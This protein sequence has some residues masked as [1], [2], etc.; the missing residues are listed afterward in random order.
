MNEETC[1]LLQASQSESDGRQEAIMQTMT[2]DGISAILQSFSTVNLEITIGCVLRLRLL[3][4]NEEQEVLGRINRL[5]THRIES[6]V[7]QQIFNCCMCIYCREMVFK[8]PL[9]SSYEGIYTRTQS[10]VTS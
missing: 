3:V 8:E 7:A 1:V 6:E 5:L 4:S 9:R 2:P 10:R